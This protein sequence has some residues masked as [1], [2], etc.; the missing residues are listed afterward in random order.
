MF[1]NSTRKRK[2]SALLLSLGLPLFFS[3]SI[4]AEEVLPPVSIK[5]GTNLAADARESND[6]QI[7]IL[8]FFS[9]KHC[10]FCR[11]V[12]EDYLKPMLRNS[13]YDNKV[14]IRKVRIDSN[15]DVVDFAGKEQDVEDFSDSYNVSMVPNL[16]LVD[17]Q[18]NQLSDPIIGI[19]NE[20]YYSAELDTAIDNSTQKI[21]AL[22][23]K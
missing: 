5:D 16:M 4:S 15:G 11:E 20:H 18:G 10:P 1:F 8:L 7:P 2:L 12:E 3:I 13:D 9:M 21:R 6:K 23:K 19:A 17:S 22:V 14:I